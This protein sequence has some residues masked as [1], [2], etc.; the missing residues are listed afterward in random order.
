MEGGGADVI[1]RVG[2]SPTVQ[3]PLNGFMATDEGQQMKKC[4]SRHMLILKIALIS[5]LFKIL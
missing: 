1:D 5:T 2:E 3:Q 4:S